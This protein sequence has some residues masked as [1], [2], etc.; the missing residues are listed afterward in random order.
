MINS[1]CDDDKK[2]E[3]GG[4]VISR[5]IEEGMLERREIFLWTDVNDD[6]AKE[7]VQKILYFD[8][9]E[10]K[11]ITLFINSPGGAITSGMAIYDAM[12]YAKS[13]IVTVCMGQAASM[14][15]MLLC[16]GA[17][18]K[19]YAWSNARIMIHQP[20][21]SGQMQGPASDI[22]IH[23]EEMLRIR[24]TLNQILADASGKTLKE[25]EADTDRD[26]FMSAAEAKEYGLIDEVTKG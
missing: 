23:A 11:D 20:L 5:K 10:K 1:K 14:G 25:I 24:E 4:N 18:G 2:E 19:R 16:A 8:G 15:A 13:D 6:S 12:Q 17:K 7:V 22:Q 3:K 9:L 26:N 21:I